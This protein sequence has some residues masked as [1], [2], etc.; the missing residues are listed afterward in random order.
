MKTR[1][2]L[3][4]LL[5]PVLLLSFP[6][7]GNSRGSF[8]DQEKQVYD[9][10]IGDWEMETEFQGSVIP[11]L[12]TLSVKDGKLAGVW[13]SMDQEMELIDLKFDGKKLSFK[14]SMGEGGQTIEFEGIVEGDEISGH[15]LSPMGGEY[16]CTGQRKGSE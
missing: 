1:K 11:A 15:Y 13:V 3:L 14:R 16:K 10:I 12:M 6:S 7:I 4:S 8:L 9:A 5:M 2:I